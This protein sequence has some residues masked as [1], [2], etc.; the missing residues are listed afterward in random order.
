MARISLGAYRLRVKDSAG[1]FVNLDE[2]TPEL[3]LFSV[4]RDYLKVLPRL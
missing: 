3:D 4:L 1:D 2:L